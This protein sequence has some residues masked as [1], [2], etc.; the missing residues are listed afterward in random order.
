MSTASSP[1]AEI[2]IH[3]ELKSDRESTIR[4]GENGTTFGRSS[5]LWV[6]TGYE[7]VVQLRESRFLSPADEVSV[8]RTPVF[9][10]AARGLPHTLRAK[11]E[12]NHYMK[13]G[14]S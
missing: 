10:H 6:Y 13:L 5:G 12:R 8:E 11:P 14:S 4:D 3:Y 9:T 1:G 2:A 7:P